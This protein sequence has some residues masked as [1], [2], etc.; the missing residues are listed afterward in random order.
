MK[1]SFLQKLQPYPGDA[2]S[3]DGEIRPEHSSEGLIREALNLIKLITTGRRS[4]L[5]D[6]DVA[7]VAQDTALRLWKW[8][9]KFRQKSS[10]MSPEEWSSFTARSTYNEISRYKTK[11]SKNNEIPLENVPEFADLSHDVTSELEMKILVQKVWQGICN[12]SLYQRQA[13]LLHSAEILIYLMQF[14]VSE[15]RIASA[16]SFGIDEWRALSEQMPLTDIE[17]VQLVDCNENHL[18]MQ[19]SVRNIKKARYDA[20]KRL[21]MLRK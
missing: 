17:I 1:R 2:P 14:G 3:P 6:A 10:E 18:N 15:E 11:L 21:E 16:L 8:H 13:L 7:D 19:A 20:R 9:K 5:P 12:L 4:S